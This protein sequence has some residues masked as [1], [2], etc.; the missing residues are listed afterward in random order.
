MGFG[1]GVRLTKSFS[2]SLCELCLRVLATERKDD[3]FLLKFKM[4]LFSNMLFKAENYRGRDLGEVLLRFSVIDCSRRY[5][6]VRVHCKG[7]LV[8]SL[9][10]AA[11]VKYQNFLA[12]AL[13]ISMKYTSRKCSISFLC[14]LVFT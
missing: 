14:K 13:E 11:V 3:P 2:W 6:N 4:S 8:L 7:K 10:S 12:L 1:V 9:C 5:G